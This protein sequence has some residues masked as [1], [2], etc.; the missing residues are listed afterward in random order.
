[1]T[2]DLAL[3]LWTGYMLSL[4]LLLAVSIA[5]FVASL[6]MPVTLPRTWVVKR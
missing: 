3:F 1:M 2:A 5:L 6:P 4:A